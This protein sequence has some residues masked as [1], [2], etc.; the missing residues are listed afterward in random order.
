MTADNLQT[1]ASPAAEDVRLRER[2]TAEAIRTK[3]RP[4]ARAAGRQ[5]GYDGMARRVPRCRESTA[6]HDIPASMNGPS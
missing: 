1:A 3:A 5:C 4:G 6:D 2:E